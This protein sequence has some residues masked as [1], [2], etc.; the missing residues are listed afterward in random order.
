MNILNDPAHR[1]LEEKGNVLVVDDTPQNLD[2]LSELLARDGFEVRPVKSGGLALVSAQ[3]IVPD[4][5]LLDIMMPGMDGYEV[6]CR[7][8]NDERTRDVPVI[9][10]SALEESVDKVKAFEVGGVDFIT[11]PFQAEEVLARVR[12]HLALRRVQTRLEQQKAQLE[13]EIAERKKTE[14]ELSKVQDSLAGILEKKLRHPEVFESIVSQSEKMRSIFQYI[15]AL[16]CSS[17]PVLITGESGVGKELI[18]KAIHDISQPRGPWVP[19]NSAGLDDNVFADTLFGHV[20]GAF[21]GAD[22]ARAGMIEKAAGGTLFLDEIGD[23]SPLSQV[24][25][26]RLIQERE[27]MPLGS[28]RTM[29]VA[30]RIVVATNV[31]LE[32]KQK[33]GQFRKDLYF[34]LCTH[35]IEIPPLRERPEDIPVLLD[36]F[37]TE[38]AREMRKN[39]PTPPA[40]LS[41]LLANYNFPG[42]VRELRAMVFNAVSVHSGRKL[43]MD[44]FKKAM[45]LSGKEHVAKENEIL[46][47]PLLTFHQRLP[48]LREAA[49]LLVREAIV[50]TKGNQSMAARLLGVTQPALSSRL[51]KI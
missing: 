27:Y 34:R 45:G 46:D 32:Q 9:F 49:E 38:A 23:L 20:K 37:L 5:I 17:E 6:C 40:E 51:K 15:E 44:L 10:I 42:N 2:L 13:Q 24:K 33:T 35:Q 19:V 48:T 30:A 7:L 29:E 14:E 28:D 50:R 16:A 11:K 41:L 8:K 25:L 3:T 31:N 1:A 43:S 12:T 26:L 39:K 47:Q 18:A 22:R 4:L 21:T 36:F